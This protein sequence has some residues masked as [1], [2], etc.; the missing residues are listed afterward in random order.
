MKA[1]TK[2]AIIGDAHM[3]FDEEDVRFFN[4]SDYDAILFVGDLASKNPDSMFRLLPVINGLTKPAFLIPGNHDTTGVRA[5]IGEVTQNQFL[6]NFGA[7]SQPGRMQRLKA[8]LTGAT[9]CGYSLHTLPGNLQMVAARPFSMGSTN[10]TINFRPFLEKEY[11]V[12]TV[13]QSRDKIKSLIDQVNSPYIILAHHGPFGLGS[14]ATDMWGADFLPQETDFGDADLAEAV[15]YAQS[16]GK[17]PLAVIAGHMHYPTKHG[18]KPKQWWA[19]KDGVLYINA[20]RWPRIFR[21]EGRLMHHHVQLVIDE[22]GK[23]TVCACYTCEGKILPVYDDRALV[24][25]AL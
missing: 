16:S 3:Q 21:H 9:L 5:I 14:K 23:S 8:E 6:I 17:A 12:S 20:A 19:M 7:S 10:R 22:Q 15:T 11:G 25:E 24:P 13:E 18:K 4:A 2:L 1:V